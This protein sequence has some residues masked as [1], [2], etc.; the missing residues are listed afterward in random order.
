MFRRGIRLL[1]LLVVTL[2]AVVLPT[3]AQESLP[4]G[5]PQG[6]EKAVVVGR[7][8][9]DK[10][11]VRIG[12]T[13][14]TVLLSG[15][16]APERGECFYFESTDYLAWLLPD[17]T[18][19][20]LQK[21]G[22]DKDSKGKLLRYV[23][24]PNSGEGKAMLINT[25]MVREGYAGFDNSKNSPKYFDRLE[26]LQKD[27]KSKGKGLWGACG[28]VHV[29]ASAQQPAEPSAPKKDERCL[30]VSD[31]VQGAF[32]EGLT[33]GT[34]ATLRG[35]QAVRSNDFQELYFVAAELEGP[36]L[37]GDDEIGVW[38]TND[39]ET[40]MG[41]YMSV[42]G[43]AQEF[44]DYPDGDTT[45]AYVTMSDEGASLAVECTKAVL[46]GG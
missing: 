40:Y 18:D 3:S 11:E 38:A 21:S 43:L 17:G 6:S 4:E 44:S 5:V 35:F 13:K 36:G 30:D 27:A 2:H 16:D 29:D 15:V 45:D 9:G 34:G 24:L 25:K 32:I 22:D 26:E 10:V 33:E 23:W 7:A 37:D 39:I 19:V 1:I 41:S 20:Y 8:D 28:G 42:N 31:Y 14:E 46:K 12:E